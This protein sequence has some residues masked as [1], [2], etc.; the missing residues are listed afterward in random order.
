[1]IVIGVDPHKS[2]HTATALNPI[3]NSEV[4]S[5]RID[6]SLFEYQRLI[7]WAKA[8]KSTKVGDRDRP[9]AGTPPGPVAAGPWRNG[10]G[11]VDDSHCPGAGAL[12]GGGRKK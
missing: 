2:T 8:L 4:G 7:T 6:A 10:G 12:R 1:M 11:R 5:L 9:G 3:T